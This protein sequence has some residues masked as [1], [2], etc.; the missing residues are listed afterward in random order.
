M[1]SYPKQAPAAGPRGLTRCSCSLC[2]HMDDYDHLSGFCLNVHRLP[3]LLATL[4]NNH[5]DFQVK[6]GQWRLEVEATPTL[7]RSSGKDGITH[8]VHKAPAR[9]PHTHNSDL[10]GT[11]LQSTS[12]LLEKGTHT[13][14]S[15]LPPATCKQHLHAGD[16]LCTQL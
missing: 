8:P 6:N 5:P 12:R 4:R 3:I 2:L 7:K 15:F 9:K 13:H 14:T 16:P 10:T 1:A 11:I